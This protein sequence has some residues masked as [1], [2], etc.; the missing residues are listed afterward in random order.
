M[1]LKPTSFNDQQG[2]TPQLLCSV[3][4]VNT[5]LAHQVQL[6]NTSM[7]TAIMLSSNIHRGLY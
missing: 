1:L 6:K 3:T 2:V 7:V 4:S 5:L